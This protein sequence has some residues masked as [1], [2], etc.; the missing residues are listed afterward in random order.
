LYDDFDPPTFRAMK[1]FKIADDLREYIVK[2]V[3]EGNENKL[4]PPAVVRN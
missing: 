2:N 4:N 3:Y 1:R